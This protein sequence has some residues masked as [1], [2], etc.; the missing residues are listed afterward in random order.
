MSP[1]P[2]Q[3]LIWGTVLFLV[4]LLI[5]FFMPAFANPRMGMSAHVA[6]LQSGMALWGLGL[7]WERMA[8]PPG[9]PVAVQ[10]LAVVGLYGTFAG[11]LLAALWGSSR[12]TPIAGAGHEASHLREAVVT[13]LLTGGSLAIVVAIAL[14]LWGLCAWKG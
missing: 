5:G 11:L 10:V 7:M 2:Q 12:A 1:I 9:T 3:L 8:L 4:A 6:G 14:V 13:G